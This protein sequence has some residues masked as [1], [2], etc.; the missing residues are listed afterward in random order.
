ILSNLPSDCRTLHSLPKLVESD[1]YRTGVWPGE[2]SP[3]VLLRGSWSDYFHK[4][5]RNHRAR[6]RK[7]LNKLEQLGKVGFEEISAPEAVAAALNDGFRIESAAW[8]KNSGTAILS[9]PEIERFYRLFAE[10]AANMGILR[11]LFLTLNGSRIAF[12]YALYRQ[13]RLYVLKSGYDPAFAQYSPSHLLCYFAI[14]G[15]FDH[16]M[17]EYDFLGNSEP[18]KIDWAREIHAHSWLF[19]FSRGVRAKLL[20]KLKFHWIPLL[21]Q[22]RKRF[23]K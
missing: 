19:I 11:L 18:W 10:Q 8:K 15:G 20:Y 13:Q 23:S 7:R 21:Q 4:L 2:S 14:Q 6:V 17:E 5:S 9:Q 1:G 12:S 22:L 3:Y 16:G